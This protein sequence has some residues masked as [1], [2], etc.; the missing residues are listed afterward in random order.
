MALGEVASLEAI[1]ETQNERVEAW[2]HRQV[3]GPKEKAGWRPREWH[4]KASA[5]GGRMI[6][7]Q[8]R[9]LTGGPGLKMFFPDNQLAQW[10]HWSTCIMYSCSYPLH[11]CRNCNS[12]LYIQNPRLTLYISAAKHWLAA[13]KTLAACLGTLAGRLGT[14]AACLRAMAGRLGTLAACLG[15]MAGHFEFK[16]NEL[17]GTER[18]YTR[19]IYDLYQMHA[20][21]VQRHMSRTLANR[22]PHPA[23]PDTKIHSRAQYKPCAATC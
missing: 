18:T 11:P 22:S 21:R 19:T 10:Q 17:R 8:I 16:I 12:T 5:K 2:T 4:R 3:V 23:P 7:N 9:V 14:L 1:I 6:D 13:W 15:A 20:R